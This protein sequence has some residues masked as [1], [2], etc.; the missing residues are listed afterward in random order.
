MLNLIYGS[1]AKKRQELLWESVKESFDKGE[2]VILFVPEQQVLE[3]EGKMTALD[4]SR[5]GEVSSFARMT[6]TVF[7]RFGGLRYHYIGK[8]AKVILMWRALSSVSSALTEYG[9]I[10][11]DDM[12]T[13]R[14]LY[15]TV[16][17]LK[18]YCI[19]PEDIERVA[20][21]AED[22][23]FSR[24]LSDIALIYAT[25]SALLHEKHND[26]SDDL[27]RATQIL[28]REG[29]G[30]FA[31]CHILL[32]SFDGFTPAEIGLMKIFFAEAEKITVTLAYEENDRREFLLKL[33][34]TDRRLR[35][36]ASDASR[37]VNTTVAEKSDAVS[38]EIAY[39]RDYFAARRP[40]AFD[41]NAKKTIHAIACPGVYEEVRMIASDIKRRVMAGARYRD[42]AI[43]ARDTDPYLG[44]LDAALEGAK[45]PY[46]ISSRRDVTAMSTARMLLSVLN[47]HARFWRREDVVNFM[48]T[49]LSPLTAD[50][51]DAIEE[52]AEVWRI[53][54]KRWFDEYGWQMNPFGFSAPYDDKASERLSYLNALREKLALPLVKLF[55]AFENEATVREIS[56]SL[57]HFLQSLPIA[58]RVA[59][60]EKREGEGGFGDMLEDYLLLH[61]TLMKTFDQLVE[62]AGDVKVNS[63]QYSRL[64][65]TLLREADL[66][67]L[68]SRIDEVTVGSASLLR[69]SDVKHV[70]VM[71]LAEGEFPKAISDNGCFDNDERELLLLHGIEASPLASRRAQDERLYFYRAVTTASESV[72]MSYSYGDL[73][74][75]KSFPSGTYLDTLLLLGDREEQRYD[76]LPVSDLLYGEP[77]IL[78]Y[79]VLNGYDTK[80]LG[81]G[82]SSQFA[83]TTKLDAE[84]DM[85]SDKEAKALYGKKIHLSQSKTDSFSRCPFAYHCKYSLKLSEGV[86]GQF[87]SLDI[88][89]FIH[90]ILEAFFSRFKDRVKTLSDEE[91]K[92]A[93]DEILDE[94]SKKL[95]RDNQSRRFESLIRRLKR[96]TELLVMNLVG[97][98]RVSEF[99]PILFEEDIEQSEE[100]FCEEIG[101]NLR[102]VT[103]GKIDRADIYRMG[104]DVYLRVVDYKT[105]SKRFSMEEVELGFQLQLLVYLFALTQ[106]NVDRVKRAA[107]VKGK[108]L[109]A[110]A[111]YFSLGAKAVSLTKMPED[112]AI[113]RKTI[114]KEI[115]RSGIFL[116]LPDV[117]N[118]M[119]ENLEGY[120]IPITL[121]KSGA[122]TKGRSKNELATLEEFGALATRISD[123]LKSIG[124]SMRQGVAGAKPKESP[125]EK[126]PCKYCKMKPI[127]RIRYQK[128]DEEEEGDD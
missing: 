21:E 42:F 79:A 61:D 65:E 125:S 28:A 127:C 47:I 126:D 12:A 115:K 95:L 49:G 117:L 45:I 51:C 85:L 40:A 83:L 116:N 84:A 124:K 20:G 10:S 30:F 44:I 1:D 123:I 82:V 31:G 57:V 58:E 96:T 29:E 26:A 113:S 66:G 67:V 4:Q 81:A 112:E 39:F 48:R 100:I 104:D 56:V 122:P 87:D 63:R 111:M 14:L 106:Q 73:A 59:S 15:D 25:Y 19:A 101:E 93:L 86:S 22:E 43:V 64:L 46:F 110:G 94:Y 70:Y 74:G 121:T 38:Y 53:S 92:A 119:E 108:V 27:L 114:E 23:A 107:A 80:S 16:E 11:L 34:E 9:D 8:G 128:T 13:V 77:E 68:P 69:K 18:L 3:A 50:E 89:T 36:L 97:E 88:G 75:K 109:P 24:K 32:D 98:F 78:E 76:Q 17:E 90:E 62:V 72:T 7:R 99:T 54:G 102:L 71:G 33:K 37:K 2:R 120:Y 60:R 52:Y 35:K 91:V 105:G 6:N 55:E 41:K 5:L 103:V 118:A